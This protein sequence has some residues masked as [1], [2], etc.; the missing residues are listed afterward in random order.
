M[1]SARKGGSL[2]HSGKQKANKPSRKY[3]SKNKCLAFGIADE[4]VHLVCIW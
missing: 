3:A 4:K 1:I 2:R